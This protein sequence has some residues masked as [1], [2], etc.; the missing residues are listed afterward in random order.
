MK[1]SVRLLAMLLCVLFAA[2]GAYPFLIITSAVG[3]VSVLRRG[4]ARDRGNNE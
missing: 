3:M 4:R 1:K 2:V